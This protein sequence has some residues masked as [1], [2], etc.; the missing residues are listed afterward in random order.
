MVEYGNKAHYTCNQINQK[1]Y[2]KEIFAHGWHH[3]NIKPKQKNEATI[4]DEYNDVGRK[5]KG[6]KTV[7]RKLSV[8]FGKQ[9]MRNQ[10]INHKIS[11]HHC[12][13]KQTARKPGDVNI[14][15]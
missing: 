6:I 9:V 5:N 2:K 10:I 8:L 15:V 13:R 3:R 4:N 7:K 12:N 11:Y 14:I 1:Q